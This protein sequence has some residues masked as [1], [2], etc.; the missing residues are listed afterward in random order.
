MGM[1][2]PHAEMFEGSRKPLLDHL[3]E[4]R[5]RLLWAVLALVAGSTLCWFYVEPIYGFLV[6][7]LADAMGP[8]STHRMIY[9]GLTEAFVTYVKIAVFAGAF[10]TS[11]I[12]ATQIWQFVA[13]G[14]YKRER[15]AFLPFLIATPILFLAGAA[16][17]YYMVMP[18]AWKFLLH[19]QTTAAQTTLPIQLEA[20][21][22]EY[23][24][25]SMSLIMA[26][27]IC[28]QMPV[29][30]TLLGRAGLIT[31]KTLSAQRKYAVVIIFTVA[32]VLTPP[33]VLSQ[34]S[35]AFP[36]L[37]LYEISIISVR[38]AEKRV[39]VDPANSV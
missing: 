7:P 12:L 25:T 9:T 27:G 11:P 10:L 17:A 2:D 31:A 5:R 37:L 24:N 28:F 33:D 35:L 34:L 8:D 14:L 22:S 3:L 20:K 1:T 21:V 39:R 4:L 13:P 6:K 18:L 15:M 38:M 32:A 16:L 26:F 19:F 23:L 30:L 36:L 29:L